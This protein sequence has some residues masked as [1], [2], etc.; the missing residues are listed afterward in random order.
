MNSP[1]TAGQGKDISVRNI[2]G[3]TVLSPVTALTQKNI[4][5]L[6]T[7]FNLLMKKNITELILDLKQV[8]LLDS[9][10]LEVLV[11]MNSKLADSGG[12]LTLSNLNDVCRDILIC[13]RLINRFVVIGQI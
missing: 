9:R 13:V 7:L 10:A 8:P 3:K 2:G 5:Q 1:D 6:E 11:D 4:D 12:R